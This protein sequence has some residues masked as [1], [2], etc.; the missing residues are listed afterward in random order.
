MIRKLL[1]VA[2][3][4]FIVAATGA[5]AQEEPPP[6]PR[7]CFLDATSDGCPKPEPEQPGRNPEEY[8]EVMDTGRCHLNVCRITV[9]AVGPCKISVTPEFV[10]IGQQGVRILW[11]L[12]AAGNFAFD[13]VRGIEF[14]EDYNPN[15]GRQF[16][17]GGRVDAK[18]WQYIDLNSERGTFRYNVNVYNTRTGLTCSYDPGLVNDWP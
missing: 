1:L 2:G 12:Q 3:G 13:P 5:W 8:P 17:A 7:D 4:L 9:R 6:P 10:F 18:T 16:V 15:F 11:E 14:K